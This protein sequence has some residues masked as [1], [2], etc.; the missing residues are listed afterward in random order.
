MAG[1]SVANIRNG[2][3]FTDP[4]ATIMSTSNHHRSR[5]PSASE[6]AKASWITLVENDPELTVDC[7]S[8]SNYTYELSA[9]RTSKHLWLHKALGV[10][11]IDVPKRKHQTMRKEH[12]QPETSAVFE[13]DNGPLSWPSPWILPVQVLMHRQNESSPTSTR[14]AKCTI[15]TGNML[16]NIVS[17]HFVEE[18]LQCP[19]SSIQKLTKEEEKGGTGITGDL[20][21]P[22]GAIDL[23]WYHKNSTRVFRDMRFLISPTKQCDLIIGARSIHKENILS[24]P[25]LMVGKTFISDPSRQGE[26]ELDIA[27]LLL[28]MEEEDGDQDGHIRKLKNRKKPITD[29]DKEKSKELQHGSKFAKVMQIIV[30]YEHDGAS[31]DLIDKEK[32][33][34]KEHWKELKGTDTGNTIRKDLGDPRWAKLWSA[35][36]EE[37]QSIPSTSKTGF[38]T[39]S[40]NKPAQG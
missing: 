28:K 8:K 35:L 31:E 39:G 16:G 14:T 2:L 23:T 13:T 24:V 32:K 40:Q 4:S 20:Y 9:S 17:R 21:I 19:K 10:F 30:K 36:G 12:G 38:T 7:N 34:L 5:S 15:D 25:C 18:V 26:D 6:G 22:E 1:T 33:D 3:L 37:P 29:S 27:T 11:C